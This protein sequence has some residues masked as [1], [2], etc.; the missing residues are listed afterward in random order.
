MKN[1]IRFIALVMIISTLLMSISFAADENSTAG[2]VVTQSTA[3]NI[4]SG[5]GTR[6]SVIGK[7]QKGSYVT[8]QRESNGWWKVEYANGKEG[9]VSAD[10]INEVSSSKAYFVNTK[11]T[12]LNVRSGPGTNY[13]IAG[14]LNK[15]DYVVVL[16]ISNGWAKVLYNGIQ[17][18]YVSSTYLAVNTS[19]TQ[20]QNHKYSTVNLNVSRMAQ[21]D[22]RWS[23]I[24]LGSSGKTIG[25]IGCLVTGISMAES[26]RLGKTI[27][28]DYTARN[29]R[30]TSSGAMY[31]PSNY[32]NSYTSDYLSAIYNLLK[33]GKP[34]LI[35]ARTYSGGQHWVL[36]TGYKGGDTL[37]TSN[38]IIKDPG[39]PNRTNLSQFFAAYPVYYKIAYYR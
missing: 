11:S 6:N 8:L 5:P 21:A 1:Q 24:K 33:E 9:Y 38:F 37:N 22:P 14:K 26:Y 23:S 13:Y 30:F 4:R 34:V 17:Q 19:L 32:V 27:T 29:S 18:G 3:L 28:P 36:V 10:Y 2:V 20:D 16:S 35:G 12:R 7:L 15:G 25:S 31:W 39:G